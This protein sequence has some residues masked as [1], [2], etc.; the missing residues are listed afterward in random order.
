MLKNFYLEEKIEKIDKYIMYIALAILLL[1]PLITFKYESL[2]ISP[3]VMN[4]FY[5][6]GVKI[7]IFSF[8]KVIFLYLGGGAILSLL[9]Y[10][11]LYLEY[12][13][14]NT[15]L[16][17]LVGILLVFIVL[18]SVFSE[19]KGIALFGNFDRTEGSL[20][21][22]FYLVIFFAIYNINI[23]KKYLKY[24]YYLLIPFLIINVVLGLLILFGLDILKIDFIQTIL[25]GNGEIGG[26]LWTT[27]YHYNFMSGIASVM[28]SLT[29]TY[30]ILEKDKKRKIL[31]LVGNIISFILVLTSNSIGGFIT[32]ILI[33][34]II[35][36]LIYKFV[37]KKDLFIISS[38]LLAIYAVIYFVLNSKNSIVYNETFSIF[39]KI[40]NISNFIIPSVVFIYILLL[41]IIKK[42]NKKK[43]FKYTTILVLICVCIG[44]TIYS[45]RIE[46]ENRMLKE[47]NTS[48]ISMTETPIFVKLNE[49]STDRLNIWTKTIDLIN[50]KPIFGNGFDTLPY[51]F[52]PNDENLGLSTYGELIDKPHNW[53]LTIAYGGGILS[54][55]CLV[56]ILLYIFKGTV[57]SSID[58]LNDKYLYI[59]FTGVLAYSIQGM[60]NDSLVGT[61][62]F[63]W[64]FAGLCVNR[65]INKM[66]E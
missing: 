12:K 32:I 19:Y 59:F 66:S 47:N 50:D 41:F 35:I 6:T 8:Y 45:M 16:N 60:F 3:I 38:L 13:L 31:A 62:V 40:S 46:K 48:V 37:D 61:S 58:K 33:I 17:I 63:F 25:G 57:Y 29:F 7:N 26:K 1:V 36:P 14:K 4:N 49:I 27:L 53:Y 42:L 24:F 34:P 54:L 5:S 2:S 51:V 11:I 22:F 65:L 56:G 52:I 9:M 64:I 23:D 44:S 18:S 15:K 28:F 55:V 39:A 43:F 20:A 21:W 10:K 30:T